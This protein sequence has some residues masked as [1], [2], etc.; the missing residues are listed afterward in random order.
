MINKDTRIYGSF[1]MNPGNNGCIFFNGMFEKYNINALYKSFYIDNIEKAVKCAKWLNFG[2]FAVSMPFKK[3]IIKYVDHV[4]ESVNKIGSCNT[5]V[6]EAGLLTAFNTDYIAV[7]E[8][9]K[10]QSE[11]I[12]LGDG[13]FSL[14]AQYAAKIASIKYDVI[15]RKRWNEITDLRNKFIFNCTPVTNLPIH[16]SNTFIDGI[17]TSETGKKLANIQAY[18][19]FYLYTGIRE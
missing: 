11:I 19:Q 9:I 16:E 15:N 5:V 17:P 18:E 8:T 13:G 4:S 6:I 14:A 1:S 12:I 3:D 10:S 7:I 2:G